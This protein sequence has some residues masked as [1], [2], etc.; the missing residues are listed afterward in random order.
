MA[1]YELAM[2]VT[3]S[4]NFTVDADSEEEALA[5]VYEESWSLG[6]TGAA[7][8]GECE[9]HEHVCKGNVFYGVLNDYEIEEV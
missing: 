7:Y 6:V 4:L 5:K 1:T 9:M 2:P 3:L 8:I